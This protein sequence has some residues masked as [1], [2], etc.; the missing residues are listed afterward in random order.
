[1][2]PRFFVYFKDSRRHEVLPRT[3][4]WSL[5]ARSA[6][7]LCSIPEGYTK[8]RSAESVTWRCLFS[9]PITGLTFKTL[10][11]VAELYVP[12]VG[13]KG[14]LLWRGFLQ[15]FVPEEDQ[16]T[17]SRHLFSSEVNHVV[18]TQRNDRADLK[19]HFPASSLIFSYSFACRFISP[20]VS[21]QQR[22][23]FHLF[24]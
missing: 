11:P 19:M 12:C 21:V 22:P 8:L 18:F 10:F 23:H 2:L 14:A 7:F 5:Q 20:P 16:L 24:V 9:L 17:Y 1:M 13:P 6:S 15:P 4:Y 3:C